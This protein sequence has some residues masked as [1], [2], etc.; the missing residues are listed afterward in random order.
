MDYRETEATPKLK[1]VVSYALEALLL[2]A[3][4]V[5]LFVVVMLVPELEQALFG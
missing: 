4:I 5:G 2:A 1:V 3:P